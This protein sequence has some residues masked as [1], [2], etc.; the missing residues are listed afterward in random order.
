MWARTLATASR[1]SWLMVTLAPCRATATTSSGV[2]PLEPSV[3]VSGSWV[4]SVIG[5]S[6][7]SSHRL[8]R[9]CRF[10]GL[11]RHLRN[12]RCGLG[13]ALAGFGHGDADAAFFGDVERAV[14]AGV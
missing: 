4:V 2:T 1:A 7:F 6:Y 13:P 9:S 14:V 8:L 10:G 3:T 12:N 5:C 11:I